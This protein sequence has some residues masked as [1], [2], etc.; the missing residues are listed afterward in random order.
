[1]RPGRGERGQAAVELLAGLPLVI[2]FGLVALQLLAV[3][4]AATLA[5]TASEAGALA[6]A[7]G[8]D[9]KAAARA[10]VPGWSRARMKVRVRGGQVRVTMRP[11]SPLRAV[12]RRVEIRSTASVIAP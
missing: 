6:I 4:Y 2:A 8:G 9:P 12:S 3:G 5:G 7:G 11:L 1:M 10:A